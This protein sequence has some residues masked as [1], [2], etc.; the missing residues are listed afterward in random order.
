MDQAGE[1][2]PGDAASSEGKPGCQMKEDQ[3]ITPL[4]P[5]AMAAAC[6]PIH[7]SHRPP[8]SP[9]RGR[10]RLSGHRHDGCRLRSS[11]V[12]R[13]ALLAVALRSSGLGYWHSLPPG[14]NRYG[15]VPDASETLR[16][17]SNNGNAVGGGVGNRT[18]QRKQQHR[19][20][21]AQRT[22]AT[23]TPALL[24]RVHWLRACLLPGRSRADA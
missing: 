3:P 13:S 24:R 5:P 18:H 14:R 11:R 17:P 20:A 4:I 12:R 9:R 16:G 1:Q 2:V 10:C 19:P 23:S 6:S 8:S 7:R 21:S 15:A 22:M